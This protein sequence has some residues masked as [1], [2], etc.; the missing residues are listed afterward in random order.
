MECIGLYNKIVFFFKISAFFLYISI[1]NSPNF[2]SLNRFVSFFFRLINPFSRN[3]FIVINKN[4]NLEYFTFNLTVIF[5]FYGLLPIFE[6]WIN[7]SFFI[8]FLL[9]NL[10]YKFISLYK[11]LEVEMFIVVSNF[12]I[13]FLSY[14][15]LS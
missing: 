15:G 14:M 7:Y 12:W 3:D 4:S 6:I 10:L 8:C 9:N 11:A 1:Y 5:L 13:R 2:E